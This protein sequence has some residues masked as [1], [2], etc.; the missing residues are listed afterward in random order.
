MIVKNRIKKYSEFQ[1]VIEEGEVKKTCFFVSYAIENELGYSRFGISVPKKTGN[2]VV[3][4]RIKRQVRSAIG[5]ST[6]FDKSI[7]MVFIVRKNYDTNSFDQ[8]LS[9]IKEILNK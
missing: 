7:D 6:K 9:E 3:R 1:K 8:A 5:Q 4:N 2:A